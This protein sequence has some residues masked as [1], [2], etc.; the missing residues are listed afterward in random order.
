[1]IQTVLNNTLDKDC[2]RALRNQD[3][4]YDGHLNDCHPDS[5]SK[6]FFPDPYDNNNNDDP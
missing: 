5:M 6:G 4:F 1:M 2:S 3:I